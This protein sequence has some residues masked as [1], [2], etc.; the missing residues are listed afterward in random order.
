MIQLETRDRHRQIKTPR[1]CA[2]WIEEQ[3][4][5]EFRPGRFVRMPAHDDV[6][7]RADGI[8]IEL[9]N[10]VKNVNRC[11]I[12]LDNFGF[13]QGLRP[14]FRIDISSHGK[15]R[16]KSFQRFENFRI[17][18]VARMD[19]QIRAFERAQSLRAQQTMRV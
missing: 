13:G 16:G 9:V 4:A 2:S 15:N 18:N 11:G 8:E 5:V 19:D 14:R 17:A 6:E 3:D 7:S 12:C 10:V 1:A